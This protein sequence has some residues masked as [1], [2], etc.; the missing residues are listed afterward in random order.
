MATNKKT[1]DKPDDKPDEK[2]PKPRAPKT[3]FEIAT[4]FAVL[5]EGE[6]PVDVLED[7]AGAKLCAKSYQKDKGKTTEIEERDALVVTTTVPGGRGKPPEVKREFY[8]L[9]PDFDQPMT[10]GASQ[11]AALAAARAAAIAKLTPIELAALGITDA[12]ASAYAEAEKSKSKKGKK[13]DEADGSADA[14]ADPTA[15]EDDFDDDDEDD[16]DNDDPFAEG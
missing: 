2:K 10:P 5:P 13:E 15:D 9:D 3:H 4:V 11:F 6:Q 14:P 16:D 1:N 8:V 12:P 7:E